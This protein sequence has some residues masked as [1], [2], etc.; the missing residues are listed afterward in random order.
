VA[1]TASDIMVLGAGQAFCELS[2][3]VS[4]QNYSD[5]SF[6]ALDNALN[7]FYQ[8]QS[9]FRELNMS[10]HANTTVDEL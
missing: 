2:L 1:D 3:L 4:Q 5:L 9:S 6:K 7:Q 8:K 10:K